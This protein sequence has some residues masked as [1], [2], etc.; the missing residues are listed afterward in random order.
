MN[1]ME[2][3]EDLLN[4]FL[5]RII[6][7]VVQPPS[8]GEKEN[9]FFV[10]RNAGS[11]SSSS[12]S[13]SHGSDRVKNGDILEVL[14]KMC[15]CI[16]MDD[17]VN[18]PDD[19]TDGSLY[20]VVKDIVDYTINSHNDNK[21]MGNRGANSSSG[22]KRMS[23]SDN[24]KLSMLV[25]KERIFQSNTLMSI[26]K[27]SLEGIEN[28]RD[29]PFKPKL[30]N[31]PHSF[32]DLELKEIKMSSCENHDDNIDN[33]NN[34]INSVASSHNLTKPSS[35]YAHPYQTEL[36]ELSYSSNLKMSEKKFKEKNLIKMPTDTPIQIIDDVTGL[37]LM[38]KTLQNCKEIA[39]HLQEHTHRSFSGFTCIMQI[40]TRDKDFIIDTI[41]LWKNMHKLQVV[42]ADPKILKVFHQGERNI[43]CLQRD[44]GLYIVNGFDTCL[45][46]T[47]PS[48]RDK[49][50]SRM[51]SSA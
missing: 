36:T 29:L 19:L 50:Q 41:V 2:K 26:S 34:T 32:V 9:G 5:R 28:S 46:Y 43:L 4:K 31:K 7:S 23:M 21:N 24:L 37:E 6:L 14:D 16:K 39:L 25:D 45:L 1:Q 10:S 38:I 40:S 51:P 15:T 33:D 47:S 49:R 11:S 17:P 8:S 35:Y 12:S 27:P 42:T 20:D 3:K 22:N 48:P 13:S 44:F 30:E 18:L